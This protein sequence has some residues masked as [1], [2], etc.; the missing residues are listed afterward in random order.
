VAVVVFWGT[1]TGAAAVPDVQGAV[2]GRPPTALLVEEKVQ[3]EALATVADTETDP[4]ADGTGEGDA[5]RLEMAGAPAALT[6]MVSVLE[7]LLV[8]SLAVSLTL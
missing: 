4:P 7:A 2:T 6:V 3:L 5:T 8:P 1:V